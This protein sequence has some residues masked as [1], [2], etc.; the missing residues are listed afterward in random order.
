MADVLRFDV[1]KL[2][3]DLDAEIAEREVCFE[4]ETPEGFYLA[5]PCRCVDDDMQRTGDEVV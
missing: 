5:V 2:N 4:L 3:A 1:A